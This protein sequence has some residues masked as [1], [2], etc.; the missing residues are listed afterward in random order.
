M[1]Y[2]FLFLA[3]LSSLPAFCMEKEEPKNTIKTINNLYG[4]TPCNWLRQLNKAVLRNQAEEVKQ[5]IEL[6]SAKQ[7]I[8]AKINGELRATALINYCL[9]SPAIINNTTSDD[10]IQAIFNAADEFNIS[11]SYGTTAL[12]LACVNNL[13][14]E[15]IKFIIKKGAS[16]NTTYPITL[17]TP[18]HEAQSPEV[19]KLLIDAGAKL[20]AK[21]SRGE[22]PLL[23]NATIYK[24]I[25]NEFKQRYFKNMR[26]LLSHG[27]A[28]NVVNSNRESLKAL[29]GD[30]TYERLCYMSSV[31]MIPIKN[32][33]KLLLT[34]SN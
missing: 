22:T 18:L 31:S 4:H 23:H 10:I 29:V 33:K 14:P 27:A 20:E 9:T 15:L 5:L 24:C 8:P 16:T 6:P 1:K 30:N 2:T 34:Q 11:D 17:S 13:K 7:H 19:I 25:S 26:T 3:T 12:H 32:Q 21:D 28:I